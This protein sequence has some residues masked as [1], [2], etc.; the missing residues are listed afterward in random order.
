MMKRIMAAIWTVTAMLLAVLLL[1]DYSNNRMIEKF[2]NGQ[3]EQNPLGF[4]GFMEPQVNYYNRGNIYYSLGQYDLARAEY[5]QALDCDLHDHQDCR[6]RVNYAL[7]LVE[8]IDPAYITDENL[9]EVLAIL[10]EARDILC[11]NGCA[12]RTDNSG[13]FPDAQRLKNEIDAFEEYLTTPPEPSPTPEETPTPTPGEDETPT[14]TP[15]DGETPTPTPEGSE[16]DTPTPTPEGGEGGPTPTPD[17]GEGGPTP[18][19]GGGEGGATPTP[20]L[21]PEEQ[22]IAIQNLGQQERLAGSNGTPDDVYSAFTN[23]QHPW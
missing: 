5:E 10:D 2:N 16:G 23:S 22:I 3:F 13:H 12:S 18:T 9:D 11:E 7:S 6:L 20:T 15:E 1:A 8:A 17:G 14:P 19:P 4:L 21:T